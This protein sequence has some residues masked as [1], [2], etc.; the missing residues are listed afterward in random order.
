[1]PAE[2]G[3][4]FDDGDSVKDTGEQSIKKDKQRPI[5]SCQAHLRRLAK[6]DI[7]LVPEGDILSLDLGRRAEPASNEVVT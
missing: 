4:R 3:F 5:R 2:D 1:M 7:H 6:E